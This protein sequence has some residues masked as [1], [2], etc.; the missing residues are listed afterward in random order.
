MSADDLDLCLDRYVAAVASPDDTNSIAA[1]TGTV[2]AV[3]PQQGVRALLGCTGFRVTRA[4]RFGEHWKLR[5]REVLLFTDLI[6]GAV[7]D[8]WRNP[9]NGECVDVFHDW[10]DPVCSVLTSQNMPT[11][12]RVGDRIVFEST[13]VETE[14]NP[15]RPHVFQRES[16]HTMLQRSE[17]VVVT[18]EASSSM[19]S[20]RFTPWLPWMLLAQTEGSLVLHLTGRRVGGFEAL[21]ESV[22]ARVSIERP[23]FA[24]APTSWT[25]RSETSWS[26]Y[27]AE[28]EPVQSVAHNR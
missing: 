6:S 9:I 21:P 8:S 28:R 1:F 22:R 5:A 18:S 26:L 20:V 16:S 27:F 25:G 7:V 13:T 11:A 15:L 12:H 23:E 14:V 2:L 24:F 17:H 3:Q 4:E 10:L 19:S